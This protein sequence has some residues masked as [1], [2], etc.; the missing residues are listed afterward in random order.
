MALCLLYHFS[1]DNYKYNIHNND[2]D[3]D[4]DNNNL[5]GKLHSQGV[6]FMQGGPVYQIYNSN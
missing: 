1:P 6:I 3:D 2:T 4:D 5:S